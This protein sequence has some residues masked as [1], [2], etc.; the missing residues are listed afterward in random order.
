MTLEVIGVDAVGRI[1]GLAVEIPQV[2]VGVDRSLV[3]VAHQHPHR[4]E[5]LRPKKNSLLKK[6]AAAERGGGG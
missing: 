3:T 4:L 2:K 6:Q 5:I 1:S